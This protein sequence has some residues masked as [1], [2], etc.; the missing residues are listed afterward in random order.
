MNV[1]PAMLLVAVVAAM[2]AY[3]FMNRSSM[4]GNVIVTQN[5]ML[6][7]GAALL[8]VGAYAYMKQKRE[9]ISV[10]GLGE[11]RDVILDGP[12]RFTIE[13]TGHNPNMRPN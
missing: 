6:M 11:S 4:S 7:A 3:L 8:A 2:A 12:S 5:M 1:S 10:Q 9:G 13:S